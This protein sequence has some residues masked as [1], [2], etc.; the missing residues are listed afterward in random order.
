MGWRA[1]HEKQTRREAARRTGWVLQQPSFQTA[2]LVRPRCLLLLLIIIIIVVNVVVVVLIVVVTTVAGALAVAACFT[3]VTTRTAPTTAVAI[4]ASI[5]RGDETWSWR[6]PI[7]SIIIGDRNRYI[8]LFLLFSLA[9]WTIA[10]AIS[11]TVAFA[12]E[13]IAALIVVSI[14]L[15][16]VRDVQRR[17]QRRQQQQLQQQQ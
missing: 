10:I 11:S 1:F 16:G 5:V 12:D 7:A 6:Y 4:T 2:T 17:R 9:T 3:T 8:I 13:S 14:Y 15:S